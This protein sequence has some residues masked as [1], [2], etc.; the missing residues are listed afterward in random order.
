MLLFNNKLEL[1]NTVMI[2]IIIMFLI[3]FFITSYFKSIENFSVYGVVACPPQFTK[4]ESTDDMYYNAGNVGIGTSSPGKKL[5]ING[6][7]R[8]SERS[9]FTGGI[10]IHNDWVRIKGTGGIHWED[11]GGG[12]HMTDS[13]WIRSYNKK[14][15]MGTDA[16]VGGKFGIGTSNPHYK[17][18]VAGDIIA[19]NGWLRTQGH[20]GMYSDTYGCHWYPNT[21]QYGT[22]LSTGNHKVNGWAGIR[23]NGGV[24]DSTLMMGTEGTR[25]GGAH[26]NGVGWAIHWANDRQIHCYNTMNAPY[27]KAHS[28]IRTKT[29]ITNL[30]SKNSLDILLKL[31]PV[32]YKLLKN[33]G[34]KIEIDNDNQGFISQE[35]NKILPNSV[36]FYEDYIPNVFKFANCKDNMIYI[37][38]NK[39]KINDKIKIF[40]DDFSNKDRSEN[41]EE[42][43]VKEINNNYIKIDKKIPVEKCFVYGCFVKD[44]QSLSY[45]NIF[46]LNVSATQELH[47]IITKQQALI[48]NLLSRV[49]KLE[50]NKFN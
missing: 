5:D 22:W 6:T 9:E 45:N 11:Y 27:F 32:K 13:S 1:L 46:T 7:L 26:F 8:V 29:D 10:Y 40:Y 2:I 50:N 37:N 3:I 21:E 14:V 31:N 48:N 39:I 34:T 4:V 20:C 38:T 33:N 25:A 47:Q 49:N 24:A 35:V 12:W 30:N 19:R 17:L 15:W 41:F 44:R 18:D 23:F 42:C 43:I 28:D 36:S 16:G